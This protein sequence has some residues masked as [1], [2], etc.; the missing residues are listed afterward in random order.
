MVD[1]ER[2]GKE[3]KEVIQSNKEYIQVEFEKVRNEMVL[4]EQPSLKK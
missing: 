3:M 2:I 4:T 1:Q